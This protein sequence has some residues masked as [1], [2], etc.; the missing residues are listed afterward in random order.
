MTLVGERISDA[1]GSVSPPLGTVELRTLKP[2]LRSL[3]RR[4]CT[5][6]L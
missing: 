2:T 3:G 6:T 4:A 1:A 5:S